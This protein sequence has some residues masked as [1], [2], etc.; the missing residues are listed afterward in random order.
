[1]RSAKQVQPAPGYVDSSTLLFDSEDE[2]TESE[3]DH[4][5]GDDGSDEGD[6]EDR[7]ISKKLCLKVKLKVSLPQ[8]DSSCLAYYPETYAAVQKWNKML[9]LPPPHSMSDA[10]TT[11]APDRNVDAP[12]PHG[13]RIVRPDFSIG[14]HQG[15]IKKNEFYDE[16]KV[17]FERLP[18][19]IRSRCFTLHLLSP[20]RIASSIAISSASAATELKFLI[21]EMGSLS[22]IHSYS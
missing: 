18:G 15:V 9:N 14:R 6:D 10:P 11:N 13:L 12:V 22:S 5:S 3:G 20:L 8:L 4:D 19:E 2:G 16:T 21:K 7:H 17:G 1:M